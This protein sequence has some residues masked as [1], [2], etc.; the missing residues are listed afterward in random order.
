M[1][2]ATLLFNRPNDTRFERMCRVLVHTA[3]EQNIPIRVMSL[4]DIQ[5][6]KPAGR[7]GHIINNLIKFRAWNFYLNAQRDGDP[8]LFMDSDMFL[9]ASPRHLLDRNMDIGITWRTALRDGFGHNPPNTGFIFCYNIARVREFFSSWLSLQEE[10]TFNEKLGEEH[11]NMWGGMNQASLMEL[12]RRDD[13]TPIRLKR[14]PCN[15]YNQFREDH[16]SPAPK[17]RVAVH[18]TSGA[19]RDAAL[20]KKKVALSNRRRNERFEE[21]AAFWRQKEKEAL[22]VDLENYKYTITEDIC[23]DLVSENESLLVNGQIQ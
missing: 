12:L 4:G 9:T 15:I 5:D 23:S 2:I 3:E 20:F 14:L 1:K 22:Y 7:K 18:L 19:L 21:L 13:F 6:P 11:Y 10:F 16:Y 17:D 8:I